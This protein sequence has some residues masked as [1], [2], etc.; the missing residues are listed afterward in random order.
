MPGRSEKLA[1]VVVHELGEKPLIL[2]TNCK[3]TKSQKSL[4]RIVEGYLSR[5]LIEEGI[6][7][8]KQSYNLEA[9][10]VLDWD[11]IKT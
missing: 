8:A 7:F 4:W 9:I 1:L 2:L 11:R 5:W 3:V 10:R 6:R